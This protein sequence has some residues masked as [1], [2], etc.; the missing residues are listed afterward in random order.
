MTATSTLPAG[1]S[2]NIAQFLI[3]VIVNAF[4]GSMIG[5]EQAVIT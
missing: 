1:L 4:V 5:L 2:V 3:V